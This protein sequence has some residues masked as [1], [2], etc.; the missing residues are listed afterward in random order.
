MG[1]MAFVGTST[2]TLSDIQATQDVEALVGFTTS[3]AIPADGKIV[4]AFPSNFVL[5][6]FAGT[7]PAFFE[8]GNLRP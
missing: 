3:L 5:T 7:T 1:A 6:N 4:V 8:F 2:M